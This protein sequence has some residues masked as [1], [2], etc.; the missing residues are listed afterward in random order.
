MTS[1]N[2]DTKVRHDEL[3]SQQNRRSAPKFVNSSSSSPPTERSTPRTTTDRVSSPS[4]TPLPPIVGPGWPCVDTDLTRL[5]RLTSRRS[6]G[7]TADLT[8]RV[9]NLTRPARPN[10][11]P[12]QAKHDGID[13]AAELCSRR[14]PSSGAKFDSATSSTPHPGR[15]VRRAGRPAGRREG[16]REFSLTASLARLPRVTSADSP[17]GGEP[18]RVERHPQPAESRG[19]AA[20]PVP[21]SLCQPSRPAR[22]DA[23]HPPAGTTVHAVAEGTWSVPSRRPGR[24]PT[25]SVRGPPGG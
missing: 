1:T 4:C 12:N 22:S 16:T 20:C 9:R 18:G 13:P 25:C 17:E 21:P 23:S 15:A 6:A 10:S 3:C 7:L 24:R 5:T 19:V 14:N 11:R 8:R 2:P